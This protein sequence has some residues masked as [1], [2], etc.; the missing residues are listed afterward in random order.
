MFTINIHGADITHPARYNSL[1]RFGDGRLDD[2]WSDDRAA[3]L[4]RFEAQVREGAD[5]VI[6]FDFQAAKDLK[7]FFRDDGLTYEEIRWASDEALDQMIAEFHT[8][9]A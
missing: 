2:F 1:A 9:G 3:V 6:A 5:S 4:A 8:R 7:L